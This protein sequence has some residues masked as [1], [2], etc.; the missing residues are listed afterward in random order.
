MTRILIADDH[1]IVRSGIRSILENEPGIQVCG[2]ATDGNEVVD[3]SRTL[4]PDL[5]VL[6]FY[7]PRRN[8][9]EAARQILSE[10]PM[11]KILFLTVV[12]SEEAAREILDVGAR[13]YVLKSDAAHELVDSVNNLMRNRL[14]FTTRVSNMVLEG[15]LN[16]NMIADRT[17]STLTS[18]ER[19]IVQL[20]AEGYVTKEV[21]SM[22]GVSVKTAE[23]HRSNIMRKLKIHSVAELVLYAVRNNI[24]QNASSNWWHATAA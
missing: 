17:P 8:G 20:I 16:P 19:E 3:L 15:Y 9:L 22:L 7:M 21:A 6:D 12:D 2:E 23:T 24:V 10:N 4:K 5:V 13:G 18:R 11:Q 14:Y 1:D